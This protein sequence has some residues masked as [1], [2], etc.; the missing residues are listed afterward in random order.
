MS[1]QISGNAGN[2]FSNS[3]YICIEGLER[4]DRAPDMI[5]LVLFVLA[6]ERSNQ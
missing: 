5:D 3:I 2:G 1:V 6:K 4:T